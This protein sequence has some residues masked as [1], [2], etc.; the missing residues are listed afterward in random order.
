MFWGRGCIKHICKLCDNISNK[1]YEKLRNYCSKMR[2][3]DHLVLSKGLFASI[4]GHLF[5]TKGHS[6]NPEGQVEVEPP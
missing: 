4:K 1:K 2:E 6:D 5:F 3:L